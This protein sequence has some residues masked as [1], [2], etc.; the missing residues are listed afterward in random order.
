MKI[1]FLIQNLEPGG[2]ERQ[3][4]TLANGLHKAGTS[5]AVAVFYPGGSLEEEL[6]Q[7]GVRIIQLRK[8]G[9]WDIA[10]FLWR[11]FRAVK[12][13]EPDVLYSFLPVAN[14]VASLLGAFLPGVR[15]V[16]GVRASAVDSAGYGWVTWLTYWLQ[17]LCSRSP[18]LIIVNSEA[19]RDYHVRLGYPAGRMTVV[20]NGIDVDRFSHDAD[21]RARQRALWGVGPDEALIGLVARL[22]PIKDHPTFFRAA[23]EIAPDYAGLRFVCVGD[24]SSAYRRELAVLSQELGIA[25]RIIW[26]GASGDMPAA[27]NALDI[28]TC[29]S[30]SESFPNVVGEAMACGVP[31]VST[32]VGDC[33]V[34]VDGTGLL[35]PSRNPGAMAAAW[36]DL[37]NRDRDERAALGRLA[38]TRVQT[39]FGTAALI[40]NTVRALQGVLPG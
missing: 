10:G 30:Y 1:L 5:V 29:A 37:L 15:V 14:L 16:W 9:R 25:E 6:A 34:I 18:A 24:G 31:C 11:T 20:W 12:R 8:R 32:D 13:E 28:A 17:K 2:C 19:G 4:I 21:A 33:A 22:D 27:Y 3:L 7:A 40:N 23:A 39:E 35:V 36:C 26:A 38:R